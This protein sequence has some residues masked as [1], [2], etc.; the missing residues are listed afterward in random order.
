MKTPAFVAICILGFCLSARAQE[1][2]ERFERTYQQI[3]R[4]TQSRVDRDF[5]LNQRAFIDYGGYLS[6]AYLSFDDANHDNHGLRQY[7]FVGYG[8]LNIDNVH[9]FYFRGRADYRN[10][11]VGDAVDDEADRLQGRVE[12]GWYRFDL[13]RYESAYHGRTIQGDVTVKAGQQFVSWG[14]GLT[15]DQYVDGVS[16]EF[17]AGPFVVDVLGCVTVPQTID[18]DISRPHFWNDT[19][20]GFYGASLTVPIQSL[21]PYAYFLFQKDYNSNDQ[22][23]THVIPTRYH[24]DSYYAGAGLNGTAGDNILFGGEFCFE[25]GHDL[26]NSYIP[27][28]NQPTAQTTDRI[29]AYAAEAHAEYVPGGKHRSRLGVEGIL[30]SGDTD[31]TITSATFGGNAPHT[32]DH[33]FNSLGFRYLGYAF[34][35]PISNLMALRLSASTFPLPGAK[36]LRELQVGTDIFIYGKL[37]RNAPVL[38]PTQNHTYLGFEPDFFVNWTVVEDVTL[39]L[40]Y[41]IFFPGEAIPSGNPDHLRQ[42][43]YASATYAF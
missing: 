31:R 36:R 28:T 1:S 15:L 13:Q 25:G 23:T 24:Y 40:R 43:V 6:F 4:D 41:G 12:E 38:E 11:N 22:P 14:N 19:Y 39:A 2:A 20:R 37:T 34:E 16:A 27:S 21:R 10:Y 33:A 42:F 3:Q 32:V 35:P 29:E 7:E 30:A 9:E 5:P 18:F 17:R 26:S 8:H